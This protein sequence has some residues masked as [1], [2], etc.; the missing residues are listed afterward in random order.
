M[1]K[2]FEASERNRQVHGADRDSTK[3]LNFDDFFESLD[4]LGG[5]DEARDD[6]GV[7]GF[8]KVLVGVKTVDAGATRSI[9]PNPCRR[10]AARLDK[11]ARLFT[12]IDEGTQH[13][14][15]AEVEKPSNF[16][17]IEA[18]RSR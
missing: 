5:L 10:V 12:G 18:Q 17:G 9:P 16:V 8:L 3:A 1:F 13:S 11:F 14:G 4:G 15:R 7:I 2:L 6:H